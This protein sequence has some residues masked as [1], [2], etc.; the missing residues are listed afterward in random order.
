MQSSNDIKTQLLDQ[1]EALIQ[2]RGYNDF[3]FRG[4]AD[5]VGI[6]S[7][8]VHHHFRTKG[9]LGAAVTSRYTEKFINLLEEEML[10]TQDPKKLLDYYIKLFRNTLIENR[11]M[12]LCGM[13][14]AEI[15]S[16]PDEVKIETK[17]FFD[18]NIEW[19][20]SV[21]KLH[22]SKSKISPNIKAKRLLALLEGAMIVSR[23]IEEDKYF[24]EV[25]MKIPEILLDR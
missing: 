18:E 3:S 12:C 13:L 2:M 21:F 23:T 9:A 4:L 17:K 10:R 19:L 22:D 8:S 20:K 24:D 1:A 25:V 14:G 15:S 7:S 16:L 11:T 5:A 6:K